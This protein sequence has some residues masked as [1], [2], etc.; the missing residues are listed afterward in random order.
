MRSLWIVGNCSMSQYLGFV[1]DESGTEKFVIGK[2]KVGGMLE[3]LGVCNLNV[4][5]YCIKAHLCLFECLEM[6]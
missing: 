2:W 5:G 4:Q 1:L 6:R 3:M